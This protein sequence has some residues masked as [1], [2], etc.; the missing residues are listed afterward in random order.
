MQQITNLNIA[1]FSL[2]YSAKK[3]EAM[4][5]AIENNADDTA[6]VFAAL[7]AVGQG[8]GLG[9][10]VIDATNASQSFIGIGTLFTVELNP[11]D[12]V[13]VDGQLF[14]VDNVLTDTLFESVA[15]TSAAIDKQPFAYK[16]PGA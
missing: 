16:T 12:V 9:T 1:K 11:G 2:T 8:A 5:S 14:T 4:K 10:G 7:Q 6:A 13:A 15:P 3:Q